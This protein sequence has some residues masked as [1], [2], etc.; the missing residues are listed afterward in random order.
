MKLLWTNEEWYIYYVI[1][2]GLKTLNVTLNGIA[3]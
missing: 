3:Q 1:K 2:C